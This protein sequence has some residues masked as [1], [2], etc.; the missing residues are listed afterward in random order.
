[1][2]CLTAC[3]SRSRGV[4]APAVTQTPPSASEAA[5]A[6]VVETEEP[7]EAPSPPPSFTDEELDAMDRG[8]IEAACIAGSTMACDRL[9]H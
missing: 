3:G 6:P 1:M 5:E 4:E 7:T 8:D 9:G 2:A